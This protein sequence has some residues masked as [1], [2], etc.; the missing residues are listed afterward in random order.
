VAF[1][2]SKSSGKPQITLVTEI[3]APAQVN[4]DGKEYILI[5]QE[6]TFY[7]GL[8]TDR[9]GAA[10]QSPWATTCDF[11]EKCNLPTEIDTDAPD[12]APF[13]GL[14]ID[15]IGSTSERIAQRKEQGKYV[16]ILDGNGKPISQGW[17]WGNNISDVLGLGVLPSI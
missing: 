1:G 15:M 10:K 17:Q 16:P 7:L 11:L 4:L 12:L 9:Q 5:S 3:V 8:S 6:I 13:D 14:V 2:P